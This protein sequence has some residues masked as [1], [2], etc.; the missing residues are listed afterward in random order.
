MSDSL[1][2]IVETIAQIPQLMPCLEDR[3][4][5][6]ALS[7]IGQHANPELVGLVDQAVDL[8]G[9]VLKQLTPPVNPALIQAAFPAIVG[10]MLQTD[11]LQAMQN[12][13]DCLRAF[14]RAA[15]AELAQWSDGTLSG[16]DYIVQVI[17]RILHP[18]MDPS[19]S[20]FIGT[21]ITQFLLKG[22]GVTPEMCVAIFTAVL[23]KLLHL[24]SARL[25]NIQGL[26][27]VLAYW[28]NMDPAAA[29]NFLAER[30][31]LQVGQPMT[32]PMPH[33]MLYPTTHP[34]LTP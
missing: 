2:D 6:T 18:D 28:I 15:P 1:C 31:A 11:D 25:H 13:C 24:N 30:G 21:F 29:L 9:T 16:Y 5:T 27:F 7:V 23:A 33:P 22:V 3:L 12:G 4:L 14:V 32:H 8:V 20:V 10:M 34:R 19:A 26:V 17:Q